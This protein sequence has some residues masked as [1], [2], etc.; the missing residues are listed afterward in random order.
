MKSVVMIARSFPPEGNAGAH[1]TLRFVKKLPSKGWQPTVITLATDLYERYDPDLLNSIPSEATV[2]AVK[3][4]DPW[5][6]IRRRRAKYSQKKILEASVEH[7]TQ[8]GI[9]QQSAG[10]SLVS[11]WTRTAES[12]CYHPDIERGWIRPAVKV[13]FKRCLTK[14]TDVIW[15]TAG[16]VS[17]F[18]VAQKVASYTG[19]P[20]VLDFRDAWTITQNNFEDRRPLWAK[21]REERRMYSLL[22]GAQSVI[23]RFQTE[24]ECYWRAYKGAL[25]ASKIYI[26]PN[27]YD[28]SIGEFSPLQGERCEI[29][30]TGTLGDYRYDSL[31]RALSVL[32][33]SS[34]ELAR[35]LHFRFIGEGT[36]V[37]AREAAILGL[38]EMVTT[39]SATSL[40]QLSKYTKNAAALLVLGRPSTMRGFELFAAA[41]VY[42]Y[43]KTGM[44]ILGILPQDETKTLL[45]HLGVPTVA[46]V[47]SESEIIAAVCTLVEAWDKRN[48]SSL[49]PKRSACQI[50]SAEQQ[51]GELARAL[52][53]TPTAEPFIP[54]SRDIPGS[55]ETRIS[56]IADQFKQTCRRP[57]G[58][59]ER[60]SDVQHIN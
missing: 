2:L 30:Y 60:Q 36:D 25:Q 19:I 42:G 28:G 39:Q 44:P 32:K 10:P 16:P 27:G 7:V 15:A 41:K 50:Y 5:Q 57:P 8:R 13:A 21:R 14:R 51:T 1:R 54:G 17:A 55:L 59:F 24:A 18:V 53:G 22:M 29:L 23:F 40:A 38:A 11:R 47:D 52:S 4:S 56:E 45:R 31:L 43:L 6:A 35:R 33:R 9:P 58:R 48:L 20:Y 46:D 26:I 37:L 3:N 34:S 49:S 12:W